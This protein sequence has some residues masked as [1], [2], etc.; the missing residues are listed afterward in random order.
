MKT[1]IIAALGLSTLLL[2]ACK[3]KKQSDDIITKKV[4]EAPRPKG[5]QQL[6]PYDWS[7][8]V[9]WLGAT[10]TLTIKRTPDE[11]MAKVKDE[12][13]T[14]YFDNKIS[15]TVTR[16]DGSTF[17]ERTFH[18]S[19]FADFTNNAYG[20]NG[21]LLGL[22]FDRAEG[23]KLVFGAS[24]G[25]PDAMSD[26]YIPL[27]VELSKSGNVVI[28]NDTQMDTGNAQQPADELEAAE[29]EGN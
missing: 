21:A 6:S 16:S 15:L 12:Q 24:V 3:E 26:E 9:E 1:Y 17:F 11:T 29:A 19:D 23:D 4:T 14:E 7:N 5:T 25:S 8:H 22:A 10:Y 20:R 13:G 27:V 2:G 18:K 28:K